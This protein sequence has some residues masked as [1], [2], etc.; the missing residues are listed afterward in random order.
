MTTLADINQTLAAVVDNTNRSSNSLE[1]FIR[2]M[3]QKKGDDLE[4]ERERKAKIVAAKA[5]NNSTSSS[6][7]DTSKGG[8]GFSLPTALLTGA[9]LKDLSIGLAKGLLKRGLPLAIATAVADDIGNWVNSKT[10][11]AE[12]GAAAERAT[13]GGTFGLIFGKKFGLI[14]A[15][16]GA[17]ATEENKAA[18]TELGQALINKAGDAKNAIQEWANSE[19]AE[20]IAEKFGGVGQSILDYAKELPT[21]GEILSGLQTKIGEGIKGLTGF[22]NGGFDDE[23]FQNNWIEAAGTLTTFAFFLAPGK[24]LRMIKFLARFKTLAAGAALYGAYKLFSGDFTDGDLST[25]DI[26]AGAAGT[27]ALAYGGVKATQALRGNSSGGRGFGETPIPKT[28]KSGRVAGEVFENKAGNKMKVMQGPKGNLYTQSV[29]NSTPVG[30]PN[31][32]WINKFPKLKFLR[33]IPGAGVLFAALDAV[34]AAQI[35]ANPGSSDKEKAQAIGSLMGGVLGGAG[36][37]KL[38]VVLGGLA[39][40]AGFAGLGTFLGG[41]GGAAA[42]GTLGYFAGDYL[43]SKI[44]G[45]LMD[46]SSGNGNQSSYSNPSGSGYENLAGAGMGQLSTNISRPN[47]DNGIASGAAEMNYYKDSIMGMTGGGANIG[48]IG[49]NNSNNTNVSQ[50]QPL[51]VSPGGAINFNDMVVGSLAH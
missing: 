14:G 27:A 31:S 24:F 34:G 21:A 6:T 39:G 41:L 43:G 17:L 36:F 51:V 45:Y 49:D 32:T 18:V 30:K 1:R 22:I 19:S 15:A 33:G 47:T 11:S 28:T 50:S 4:A 29:P 20:K 48:Q 25:E 8:S 23:A 42:M 40:T 16:V 9:A 26:A 3:E 7:S 2:S 5:S 35:M 37:A 46:N 10:G 13:L 44:M 38:G 12:L